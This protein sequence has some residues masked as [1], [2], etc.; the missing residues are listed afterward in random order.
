MALFIRVIQ[1]SSID[2]PWVMK[3]PWANFPLRELF[4][5]ALTAI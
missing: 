1:F 3:Y 4:P 2:V 5:K